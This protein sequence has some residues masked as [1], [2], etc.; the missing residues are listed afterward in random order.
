VS[1]LGT[2]L[3]SITQEA[4]KNK[5]FYH[6]IVLTLS[7]LMLVHLDKKTFSL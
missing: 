5:I 7:F 1:K 6:F 4:V 3:I 2:I